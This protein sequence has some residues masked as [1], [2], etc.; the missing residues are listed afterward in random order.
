ML[1]AASVFSQ[2]GNCN[3]SENFKVLKNETEKNYAGFPAKVNSKTTVGYSKLISSVQQKVNDVSDA[4]KCFFILR[5]YI[6][7]FSDKHFILS[8]SNEKDFDTVKIL[9][10]D[11]YLKQRLAS[12]QLTKMEGIWINSDTSLKLAIQWY[13]GNIYKAIVV[14]SN[15]PKESPGLVY[16]TITPKENGYISKK[17]DSFLTTDIPVVQTGNLLQIWNQLMLGKIYPSDITASEREELM[18]WGN[19][20][21]GLAFKKL[22]GTTAYIRIPSFYNNDDKV[23]QLVTKND[24]VIKA[25]KY[26]II[27]L[28]GNGGGSTGWVSLVPY[29]QTGPIRQPDAYLRATADNVKATMPDLETFVTT[30]IPESY[31][32]YFPDSIIAKY[33]KAHSELPI[34]KQTFYPIPA[35]IFP[36]DSVL[37]RPEKIALVVDQLCGSS[38]EY[39][40]FLSRQ[41]QKSTSY[42]VNTIG[43]MDYQGMSNPTKLPYDKFILTIPIVKSS[44]TDNQP[45]DQTGFKPDKSLNGIPREAWIDLIKKDM[46]QEAR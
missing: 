29:I 3:C 11:T 20:N 30:P 33:K 19:N 22:S 28:R 8:Y 41:S 38:T 21:Y 26:L 9:Y 37:A 6:R 23:Q 7:F 34:T 10:S 15:N 43:M 45:I 14:E 12:K 4:K 2:P 39:F 25:C 42:G 40:M 13:P 32:K 31:Q 18:S 17:Y 27:D 36:L 5:E 24:S 46:E 1:I 44:W 35:V 16:M